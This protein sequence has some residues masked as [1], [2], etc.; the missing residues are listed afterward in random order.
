MSA[1]PPSI[2]L[3]PIIGAG[4][5]GAV[6]PAM[7]RSRRKSR[8]AALPDIR[9]A[10]EPYLE[11]MGPGGCVE[12]VRERVAADQTG[13][14]GGANASGLQLPEVAMQIT[15]QAKYDVAVSRIQE[16]SGASDDTSEERPT[17]THQMT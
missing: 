3:S 9:R 4:Q 10:L 2:K 15:T 6:T 1:L 5:W 12:H 8:D 17:A 11:F 16:L 13:T 14:M 7:A